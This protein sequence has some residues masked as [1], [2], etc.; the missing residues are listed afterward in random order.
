MP[1][2]KPVHTLRA[3]AKDKALYNICA[4][5]LD[6]IYFG[7][8]ENWEIYGP[9]LSVRLN[10]VRDILTGAL[11]PSL[12]EDILNTILSRDEAVEAVVR[13]LAIQLLLVEGV[14]SV[15]VGNF[16][17]AYHTLVLHAIAKNGTSIHQLDLR[18]L[19]VK[20]EHKN[21][22]MRV[23]RKLSDI[24]RL[25]LRYTCDDDM[26]TTLGK[27]CENLQKLDIAGSHAITEEG[28]KNLCNYP[29]RVVMNKLSETLQI[30]NLGGP[31]SKG[32]PPSYA[33]YLLLHL[34]HLVSLGSYERAGAAVDLALQ[35]QPGKKFV[36]R[37]LHDVIIS[38]KRFISIVRACPQLTAIYFDC[39]K[40]KVVHNLDE[41]KE[42]K[43]I[44][45]NKVRWSDVEI[46]LQKMGSR[47][48]SLFLLS[49]FG[50]LDLLELGRLCPRLQRLELHNASLHCSAD[51]HASAFHQV[52]ELFVY[53]NTISVSCVKLLLNQCLMVEHFALGDSGHLTDGLLRACLL[54]DTLRHVRHIWFGVAEHLTV[55]ALQ[56]LLE[57][58]PQLTSLGNLAAWD[59]R[60]EHIDLLR[61][62]MFLTNRDLTLHEVG[63]H[64]SEE[65]WI[66]ILVM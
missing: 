47:V 18:G 37:Y 62:E 35:T 66:P 60:P 30:V 45:M 44:K 4:V 27:Y 14:R 42:L 49:V 6:E 12:L 50:Q 63:P 33:S 56:A 16:P 2:Y 58:C 48:R 36:L 1:P 41:L 39:P 19:W 5:I 9:T 52:R 11:T 31:G 61:V 23:L 25:T 10:V 29:S 15:S 8:D 20:G 38:H 40:D 28:L 32:L 54:Q 17:E 59:V 55:Q 65:E 51:T 46:M 53:T 34:P 3:F 7:Q 43:E 21:A 24:R 13:Y 22:L 57:H 26:L 64:E